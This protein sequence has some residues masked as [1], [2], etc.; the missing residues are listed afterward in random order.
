MLYG[1]MDGHFI[2]NIQIKVALLFW[3]PVPHSTKELM[4]PACKE[5]EGGG[6]CTSFPIGIFSLA[7]KLCQQGRTKLLQAS[8]VVPQFNYM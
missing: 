3:R 7:R 4:F 1:W 2:V 6:C 8:V 5:R